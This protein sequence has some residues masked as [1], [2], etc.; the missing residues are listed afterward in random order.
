ME[1]L[2][3]REFGGCQLLEI[4]GR[5]GMGYVYRALQKSLDRHVAVKLLPLQ[6]IE[7]AAY[8]ERFQ[9]EAKAI[10]RLSHPNVVQVFDAGQEGG[11]YYIIMELV[12][13]GTLKE[14]IARRRLPSV[15]EI[16]DFLEQ[17]AMGLGAAHQ[18]GIVHR[19]V[20]PGN[21]MFTADRRVKVTD[22]GLAKAVREESQD[23]TRTGEVVG[24]PAYMSPEQCQ[25]GA[26]DHR[27][28]VYS[29]G[30]AIF[31]F[32]VGKPPFSADGAV[33][34]MLKHIQER[35]EEMLRVRPD[36]P[37]GLSN[38]IDRCLAKDPFDRYQACDELILDIHR[39]AEGRHVERYAPGQ[40]RQRFMAA[41]GDE[42]GVYSAPAATGTARHTI[43]VQRK[44]ELAAKE[45][46]Q[47]GDL[48]AKRGRWAFAMMAYKGALKAFPDSKQLKQKLARAQLEVDREVVA[49]DLARARRLAQEGRFAAAYDVIAATIK[50]ATEDEEK[51]RARAL[52]GEI[53]AL[54]RVHSRRRRFRLIAQAAALVAAVALVAWLLGSRPGRREPAGTETASPVEQPLPVAPDTPPPVG[55]PSPTMPPAE[56]PDNPLVRFIVEAAKSREQDTASAAPAAAPADT[57]QPP[58]LDGIERKR[59]GSEMGLSIAVPAFVECTS[60]VADRL[61]FE[62]ADRWNG[63][64]QFVLMRF[65]GDLELAEALDAAVADA[66]RRGVQIGERHWVRAG[67]FGR[68]PGASGAY[69][70]GGADYQMLALPVG[71]HKVVV[72]VVYAGK[73][74]E[75]LSQAYADVTNSA[76]LAQ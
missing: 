26:V 9:L 22:F 40:G 51:Q 55:T 75:L 76:R 15:L 65:D 71:A 38:I 58:S 1:D 30:A 3:G 43:T 68:V 41:A 44:A 53:Q 39:A 59:I 45:Q 72:T 61:V 47:R 69:A 24:T 66:A 35:P 62:G 7:D 49:E 5:G 4:I 74:K 60:S 50:G 17:S 67:R 13:G 73:H 31:H 29:L 18:R 63:C 48:E 64:W 25:A 70:K 52:L 14:L 32:A 20:K 33:Q 8:V 10:A 37:V 16:T 21:I 12:E 28:D 56:A 36:I 57:R 54:E 11:Y 6:L 27:S 46:E 23:I 2:S 19:D 34:V 42:P